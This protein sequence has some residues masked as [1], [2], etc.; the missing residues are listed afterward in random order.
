M[1]I[2]KRI[3]YWIATANLDDLG[4]CNLAITGL[5]Y[6]PLFILCS[7]LFAAI[8]HQK[9]LCMLLTLKASLVSLKLIFHLISLDR[10]K[11]WDAV[12]TKQVCVYIHTTGRHGTMQRRVW[13]CWLERLHPTVLKDVMTMND[14]I[15]KKWQQ[16]TYDCAEV[17][18]PFVCWYVIGHTCTESSQEVKAGFDFD[19]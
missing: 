13:L 11:N 2:R 16:V 10:H 8:L 15:K 6:D 17:F 12:G 7:A 14:V 5:L 4:L 18:L 1:T 9:L 19:E 3:Q